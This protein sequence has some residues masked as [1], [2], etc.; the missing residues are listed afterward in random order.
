MSEACKVTVPLNR[1]CLD[2]KRRGRSLCC[3]LP[4]DSNRWFVI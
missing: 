4:N 3:N 2:N 1:M